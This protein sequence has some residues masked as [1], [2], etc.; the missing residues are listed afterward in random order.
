MNTYV[1]VGSSKDY[2]LRRALLVYG[3]SSY[4]GYPYRHPFATL[5]D[6]SHDEGEARLGAAQ[7]LTPDLLLSLI[8]DLGESAGA[9]FL[10]EFVLARTVETVIWWSPAQ[11]RPMFFTD[12]G[13]DNA[14]KDLTGRQYPHPPLIFKASRSKL[15]VRALTE[16]KRPAARTK[17]C[18]APYWNS[19]DNGVVCTGTMGIPLQQSITV[20]GA[21]E[22]S[23]FR[24]AFSHA[25]GVT[26]HTKFPGGI[27]ALWRSLRGKKRFPVRYLSSLTQTVEEFVTDND[28]TY[29]NQAQNPA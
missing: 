12:R 13:S 18:M 22:E 16:N 27:L 2:R 1:N 19:Y 21:W 15:W 10:P 4:D 8:S 6:V 28:T 25:A 9:E 11:I 20:I 5:H 7:L 14:L 23:F 24:S 29:R 3:E 17:L 26:K